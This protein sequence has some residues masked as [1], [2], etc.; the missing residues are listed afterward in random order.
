VSRT[1]E[2]SFTRAFDETAGNESI[3]REAVEAGVDDA[4][5]KA[6]SFLLFSYGETMRARGTARIAR[7]H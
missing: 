5:S 6:T 3:F 1:T 4:L 7:S 2:Y